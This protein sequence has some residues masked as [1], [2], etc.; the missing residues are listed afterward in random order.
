MRIKVALDLQHC[1]TKERITIVMATLNCY[2][3]Q[4][5]EQSLPSFHAAIIAAASGS[6][7]AK[8]PLE[9]SLL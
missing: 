2:S 3:Q 1:G 6:K 7:I 5:T 9:T 4:G 8:N